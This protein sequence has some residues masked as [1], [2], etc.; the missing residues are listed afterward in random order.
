MPLTVRDPAFFFDTLSA[1]MLQEPK[2]MYVFSQFA[3]ADV[4]FQASNG[5]TIKLNRYPYFGDVGLSQEARR[6]SETQTIGTATPVRQ[7]VNQV[8]VVLEEFSG[9]YSTVSNS[10]SPLG[11]TERV[12]RRAEQ[13]LLDSGD[14][15]SFFNSIGGA[16]LKDDHDRVHDRILCNLYLGATNVYNPGG[17]ANSATTVLDKLDGADLMAIKEELQMRNIPTFGDG[18]YVAVV[19]PRMEKHLRQDPEFQE[20][21]RYYSPTQLMRGEIGIYEGFRFFMSTNMGTTTVN[22]LTAYEGV[23]FG[24]D[25]VGFG[26]GGLPLQ[27]RR[28]KNDDYERFMYLI[29]LVY[30]GYALMDD[31]FIV[32]A[33][34]FAA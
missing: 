2:P 16:S 17:V 32:K 5:D 29:W 34:T 18:L 26:E 3:T 33:R 23:F 25:A 8:T 12:A 19:P 10:V 15:L 4:D 1:M 22:A 13:K 11:V 24:P 6:L 28:N 31:R 30:R 27:I 21:M 9:P 20:S 14:P 7:E